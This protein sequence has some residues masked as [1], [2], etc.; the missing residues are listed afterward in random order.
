[1]SDDDALRDLLHDQV[2][3]RRARRSVRR[4]PMTRDQIAR[5]LDAAALVLAATR[6]LISVGEEILKERRDRLRTDEVGPD[7]PATEES[8]RRER[9][10][11]TY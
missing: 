3:A 8:T 6:G 9:I 5:L 10:D 7:E 4:D 1:V 2:V 11:L